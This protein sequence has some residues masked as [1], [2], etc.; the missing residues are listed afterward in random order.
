MSNARSDCTNW[1]N[2]KGAGLGYRPTSN[3]AFTGINNLDAFFWGKVPGESDGTSNQNSPRYDYH[4]TSQDSV[5]PAPEAGVWF[6]SYF[7]ALCQ[8]ANPPL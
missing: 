2:I 4:C 1:C 6:P 8:N 5:V 3:T 7:V